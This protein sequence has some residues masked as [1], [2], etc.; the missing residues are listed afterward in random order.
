MAFCKYH[1]FSL[2][3]LISY[4]CSF[5]LKQEIDKEAAEK[6]IQQGITQFDSSL[7][8]QCNAQAAFFADGNYLFVINSFNGDFNG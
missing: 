2:L 8:E 1:I 5:G 6:L 4:S 3:F 7:L